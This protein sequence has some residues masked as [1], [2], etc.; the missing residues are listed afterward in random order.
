MKKCEQMLLFI[1]EDTAHPD[2]F[3]YKIVRVG[4]CN[5]V[6]CNSKSIYSLQVYHGDRILVHSFGLCQ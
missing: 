3:I 6:S 1:S 4:G 5:S 2:D